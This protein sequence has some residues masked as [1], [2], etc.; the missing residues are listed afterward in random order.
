MD[1]IEP[2]EPR[3]LNTLWLATFLGILGADRFYLGKKVSGIFKLMTIGGLGLW[4]LFDIIYTLSGKRTNN[5]KQKLA[6]YDMDFYSIAWGLP[7]ILIIYFD[8]FLFNKLKSQ[9]L[10]NPNYHNLSSHPNVLIV[11]LLILSGLILGPLMFF[12][13]NIVDSARRKLWLWVVSNIA[14]CVLG[15][16][17]FTLF[18]YFSVRRSTRPPLD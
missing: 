10:T 9:L 5:K 15:A 14:V 12:G 8:P 18:Y 11:P 13:F 6:G 4:T 3:F 2:I 7:I 17:V 16:G 1:K